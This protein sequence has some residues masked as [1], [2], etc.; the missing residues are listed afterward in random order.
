MN[1]KLIKHSFLMISIVVAFL[2]V[3]SFYN[4]II[5]FSNVC[6]VKTKQYNT[7]RAQY[8]ANLKSSVEKLN[9]KTEDN[10]VLSGLMINRPESNGILLICHGYK[11]SKEHFIALA[12]LFKEYTVVL[13]DLRAHGDSEGKD[14]SFGYHEYKDVCAVLNFIRKDARCNNKKLYGLGISMGAASL[15]HAASRGNSFDA[16]VLDSC[17]SVIDFEVVSNFIKIP[18]FLFS[19]GKFLFKRIKGVDIDSIKPASYLSSISCP[20]MIIHSKADE[21]VDISHAHE[22][23]SKILC[24]MK[25]LVLC[26]GSHGIIFR[27]NPEFYKATI[28]EFLSKI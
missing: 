16:L 22:L 27:H 17:F 26:E 6:H 3:S 8:Y 25:S 19:I 28:I 23:Y 20:I 15:A 5:G 4:F 24:P 7:R 9:L 12:D 11:Q 1:L 10:L 2:H 14:V 13:F 21:K 18:R